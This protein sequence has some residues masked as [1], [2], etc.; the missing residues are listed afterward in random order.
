MEELES[1]DFLG[2]PTVK[3]AVPRGKGGMV[4]GCLGLV[5]LMSVNLCLDYTALGEGSCD[6]MLF[7]A[8][9]SLK[10]ES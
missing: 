1:K 5:L 3:P 2:Q 7:H 4:F 6:E 10:I 8:K 9:Y